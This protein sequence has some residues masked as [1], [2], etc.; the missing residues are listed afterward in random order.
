M[1]ARYRPRSSHRYARPKKRRAVA[2]KNPSVKPVINKQGGVYQTTTFELVLAKLVDLG[3]LPTGLCG[4]SCGSCKF[5]KRG[6]G[7]IGY[8]KHALIQ[9][10]VTA[11][12]CCAAYRP[13]SGWLTPKVVN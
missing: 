8:C 10:P 3:T 9:Q 2:R 7:K 5:F 4:T 13:H 12:M 1:K 6:S 11:R